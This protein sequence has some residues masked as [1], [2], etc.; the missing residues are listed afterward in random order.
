MLTKSQIKILEKFLSHL[1]TAKLGYIRGVYHSDIQEVTPIYSSLGHKLK[2]PNCAE[3]V[4]VMFKT[5][6]IE[7]DKAIKKL[8]KEDE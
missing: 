1:K 5:L 6:S 3:C 4:L 7:Y 8:K 2:N